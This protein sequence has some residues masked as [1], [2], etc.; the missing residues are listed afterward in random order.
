MVKFRI[1][2]AK[3]IKI[4]PFKRTFDPFNRTNFTNKRPKKIGDSKIDPIKRMTR[5]S[6]DPIKRTP[7]YQ[8]IDCVTKLLQKD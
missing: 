7:L 8:E 6:G 3:I 2:H 1:F 5:L 4:D